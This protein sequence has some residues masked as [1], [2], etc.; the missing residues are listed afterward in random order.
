MNPDELKELEAAL[1][2]S[3]SEEIDKIVTK[4][5]D[6]RPTPEPEVEEIKTA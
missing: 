1:G 4:F 5:K 3:S 6:K 2:S